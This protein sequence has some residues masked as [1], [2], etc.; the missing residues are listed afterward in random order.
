[1]NV[2]PYDNKN[3]VLGIQPGMKEFLYDAKEN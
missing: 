1:M 2:P 3:A